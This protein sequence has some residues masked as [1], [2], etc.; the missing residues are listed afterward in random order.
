[1]GDFL[2]ASKESYPPQGG[3]FLAFVKNTRSDTPPTST[4]PRAAGEGDK[5]FLLFLVDR[6]GKRNQSRAIWKPAND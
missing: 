2:C 1:F 4:L 3:S 5:T 6:E